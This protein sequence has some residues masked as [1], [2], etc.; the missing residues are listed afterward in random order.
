MTWRPDSPFQVRSQAPRP[1]QTDKDLSFRESSADEPAPSFFSFL[2]A[3]L[4][5]F[6]TN[7]LYTSSTSKVTQATISNKPKGLT[8]DTQNGSNVSDDDI[9][10][11]LLPPQPPKWTVAD[12]DER[13]KS[14]RTALML[15][16]HAGKLPIADILIEC[17]A[18]PTLQDN[19]GRTALFH[20]CQ[21]GPL[22]AGSEGR[23]KIVQLLLHLRVSPNSRDKY[24][25]SPLHSAVLSRQPGLVSALLDAKADVSRPDLFNKTC[26]IDAAFEHAQRGGGMAL[27][28]TGQ[29][30]DLVL[31]AWERHIAETG[32]EASGNFSKQG[33]LKYIHWMHQWCSP[34]LTPYARFKM[35]EKGM[36]PALR[37]VVWPSLTGADELVRSQPRIFWQLLQKRPGNSEQILRDMQTSKSSAA[38]VS[39]RGSP[40]ESLYNVLTAY[41]AYD[42]EVGNMTGMTGLASLLL[43]V[44]PE[45]SA[46]WSM[47]VLL[48]DGRYRLRAF[49]DPE[50]YHTLMTRVAEELTTLKAQ[51]PPKLRAHREELAELCLKWFKTLFVYDLPLRLAFRIWDL[52]LLEGPDIL[53]QAALV[54]FEQ[55]E[56]TILHQEPSRLTMASWAGM[57]PNE[58]IKRALKKRLG[59]SPWAAIT[60]DVKPRGRLV[61]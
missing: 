35:A 7:P 25:Q 19:Q 18:S 40:Q 8:N 55:Q 41:A 12:I 21:A 51:L 30:Y 43:S 57:D 26:V 16:C 1:Q 28:K 10:S 33:M 59:R 42:P 11:P 15:A 23:Y 56:E 17:G 6:F 3:A 5:S 29:T 49:Y 50:L 48:N 52:L 9:P 20:A 14:G 37:P 32:P 39:G 34:T 36:R 27:S 60:A 22:D 58:F 54:M 47:D 46:F 2:T 45:E 31:K 24:R 13:D 53:F 61:L 38:L 44:M 4:P